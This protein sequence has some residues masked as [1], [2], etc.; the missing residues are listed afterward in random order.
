MDYNPL[1]YNNLS[2][3]KCCDPVI[4]TVTVYAA[5]DSNR[6]VKQVQLAKDRNRIVYLS[7]WVNCSYFLSNVCISAILQSFSSGL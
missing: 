6:L 5:F 1:A 3:R 2:E 7:K 4:N